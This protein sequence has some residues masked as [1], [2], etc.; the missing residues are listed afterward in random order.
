MSQPIRINIIFRII[1]R[2]LKRGEFCQDL[3][4]NGF[5]RLVVGYDS[6]VGSGPEGGILLEEANNRDSFSCSTEN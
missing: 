2:D 5:D 4:Q 6:A 3:Q 1:D